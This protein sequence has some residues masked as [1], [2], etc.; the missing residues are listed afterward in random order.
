ME[1][2]IVKEK[3]KKQGKKIENKKDINFSQDN[4]TLN[5][6]FNLNKGDKKAL[7]YQKLAD[8]DYAML[9]ASLGN[10][11]IRCLFIDGL[12]YLYFD[13]LHSGQMASYATLNPEFG[14]SNHA[15]KD[16]I[17]SLIKECLVCPDRAEAR[18]EVMEYLFNIKPHLALSVVLFL[19]GGFRLFE[20]VEEVKC[21]G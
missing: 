16:V 11:N 14:T 20:G 9:K 19:S 2:E 10:R 17:V 4:A 12:G 3:V 18:A 21:A 15:K 1:K 6:E 5:E 8:D 13:E 7:K